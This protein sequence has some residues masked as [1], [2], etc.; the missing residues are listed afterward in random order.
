MIIPFKHALSWQLAISLPCPATD[1]HKLK[2]LPFESSTN[3]AAFSSEIPC[4]LPYTQ[5]LLSLLPA[6][7]HTSLSIHSSSTYSPLH[8]FFTAPT[9]SSFQSYLYTLLSLNSTLSTHSSLCL[10]LSLSTHTPLSRSVLWPTHLSCCEIVYEY[11]Y[12]I[13]SESTSDRG[14][15]PVGGGGCGRVTA[16]LVI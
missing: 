15:L 6:S 2:P 14:E 10:S 5:S 7:L 8:S 11:V 16:Q 9:P 1:E 3:L 4:R 12:V 13:L